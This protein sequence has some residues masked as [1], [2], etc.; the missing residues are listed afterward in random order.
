MVLLH[1]HLAVTAPVT[2][3]CCGGN[4]TIMSSASTDWLAT[5]RGRLGVAANNWLFFAT[6]DAA[7]TA[8]HGGFSFFDTFGATESVSF[9]NGKTGYTVGGG[10][11]AGLWGRW[12]VKAEY[13]YV[14]F[15]AVSATGFLAQFP[16]QPLSHNIDL[17]AN[18]A[19]VGLNYRF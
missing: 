19:R 8:L 17:K 13:L 18:I 6:G 2:Y 7:F 4:F 15:G 16:T 11:E 1:P 14:N 10:V 3:T 12:T 5:A 9:S